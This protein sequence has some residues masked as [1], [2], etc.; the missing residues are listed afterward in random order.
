MGQLR[1]DQLRAIASDPRF[2]KDDYALLSPQDQQRFAQIYRDVKNNRTT[3]SEGGP[4]DQQGPGRWQRG[5]EMIGETA[6]HVATGAAKGLGETASTLGR[7]VSHT[8][9]IAT[10]LGNMIGGGISQGLYGKE[11][12]TPPVT[13]DQAFGEAESHLKPENTGERVGKIG[14]QIAEYLIPG[15]ASGRGIETGV[16]RAG[17]AMNSP[18][19]IHSARPIA[20]VATNAIGAAG[21]SG[22]HGEAAPEHEAAAGA[23][24]PLTASVIEKMVP[25]LSKLMPYAVGGAAGHALGGIGGGIVGSLGMGAVARNAAKLSPEHQ[26]QLAEFVRTYGPKALQAIVGAYGEWRV[27]DQKN[28]NSIEQQLRSFQ[29]TDSRSLP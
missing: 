6:S 24:V 20:S 5:A 26:A 7:V 11:S 19:L 14:E 28:N 12:V 13:A 9:P 10:A 22:L 18:R 17:M 8:S 21:V 27:H 2:T 4:S 29:G 15:A 16:V 23:A 3:P 25:I 1:D